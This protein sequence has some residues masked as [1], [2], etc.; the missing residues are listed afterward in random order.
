MRV[1]S[2]GKILVVLYERSSNLQYGKD[3]LE[4]FSSPSRFI[5]AK[6]F[7][8]CYCGT[9]ERRLLRIAKNSGQVGILI[10]KSPLGRQIILTLLSYSDFKLLKSFDYWL[11]HTYRPPNCGTNLIDGT[12][13]LN[14][15]FLLECFGKVPPLLLRVFPIPHRASPSRR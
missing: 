3:C 8:F 11:K 5:G 6:R 9:I 12:L 1:H 7:K 15:S 4:P 2:I 13:W 10:L 14:L